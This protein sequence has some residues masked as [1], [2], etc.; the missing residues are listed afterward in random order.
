VFVQYRI[1][2]PLHALRKP[3][4]VASVEPELGDARTVRFRPV[5][6]RGFSFQPGQFAWINLGRSPF[7]RE[8]H[9]ISFSSSGDVASGG[10][11]AFTI[12]DLGDWSGQVVPALRPGDRAWIDGPYGALS[13]DRAEGPG[14]ALV[15]GGVG[16]TPMVSMLETM[17]AREDL[18][19][20]VL[21]YG[22]R[23][24]QDLT[25]R[26]QIEAV[27]PRL[28]LKKVYV[29]ENAPEGWTGETGYITVDVLRRH[30]P[31]NHGRFQFFVCGP[32]VLMDAM[33]RVI[34]SI[35]IPAERIH[36]ERFDMA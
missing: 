21:F 34:P 32:P 11:I 1:L 12:R 24:E 31:P 19:P 35:G 18:R 22:V 13:I 5:G 26:Q 30:L 2:R 33:E 10:E 14:F 20:V 17:A 15:A 28:R 23:S 6:H 36:A 16:I 9:P 8:Q 27:A 29:L 4:E 25:L 3:W 7:H